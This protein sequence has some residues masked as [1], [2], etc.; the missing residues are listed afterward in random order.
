MQY[1][2][3]VNGEKCIQ[4]AT[5]DF[6]YVASDR[7]P[8]CR[9]YIANTTATLLAFYTTSPETVVPSFVHQK[10]GP[11]RAFGG[12]Q[13]TKHALSD[14]TKLDVKTAGIPLQHSAIYSKS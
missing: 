7:L 6:V 10:P 8:S 1:L 4:E 3:K 12:S 11:K 14:L 2:N 9:I 13:Q 5:N